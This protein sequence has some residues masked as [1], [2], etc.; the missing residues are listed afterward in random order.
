M[1]LQCTCAWC[2]HVDVLVAFETRL[3]AHL[4][5]VGTTGVFHPSKRH[6]I[7]SKDATGI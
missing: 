6:N 3:L 2:M 5:H 7:H 4:I 1:V